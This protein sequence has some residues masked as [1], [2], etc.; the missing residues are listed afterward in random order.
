MLI[1]VPAGQCRPAGL[2]WAVIFVI[3]ACLAGCSGGP[4]TAGTIRIDV[5]PTTSAADQPVQ[6]M[7]SGLTPD[8][9]ASLRLRST[10]SKGVAWSSSA[11]F[12]ASPAGSIDPAHS[13]ALSGSYTG[14]SP[15]GLFWSMRPDRRAAE[16]AYFWRAR[17]LSF[18]LSVVTGDHIQ[19]AVRLSRALSR[20]ALSVRRVSLRAAGFYGAYFSPAA[21]AARRPALVVLGGSEGGL[22]GTLVAALLAAHGYPAL[23]VAYF[24][25]PGLPAQLS[26]I[27]LEYFARALRW[28]RNRPQVNP[29]QV[30]T[31]GVSR[32]SEAA[33]LLGAYYP[34]L[35]DGV[36]ASVP[37]DVAI[38]SYPD[39][40]GPAWTLHGRPLPYTFEFDNPRPTDD[41]AAVIP[42]ERIRGP[43]FLDC[44]GADAVWVSCPYAQAI[45]TRL[46]AHHD[47]YQHVLQAYPDAGHGAGSLVPD[48]PVAG[49]VTPGADLAGRFPDANPDAEAALWPRLLEFLA[50]VTKRVNGTSAG[51]PP[52]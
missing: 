51:G 52:A 18:Q 20:T 26:R 15:M 4:T 31:L 25:A 6:I 38:C 39:C 41:P 12:R 5:A 11:A 24:N 36:I 30:L 13:A 32:G 29:R 37:S 7:V 22:S 14:V 33:L 28:L 47:A 44:G 34:R 19:A 21:A 8:T 16:G 35:V 10:D 1:R 3:A 27:P 50:G 42:V 45:M 9:V 2:I 43:V 46:A 40:N 17:P 23:A 49:P 48:E